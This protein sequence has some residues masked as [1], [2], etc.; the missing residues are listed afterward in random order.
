MLINENRIE[1]T[2]NELLL[3]TNEIKKKKIRKHTINIIAGQIN[4][5]WRCNT[6]VPIKDNYKKCNIN[7]RKENKRDL[8][9]KLYSVDL[10]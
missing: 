7:Y 9:R 2:G 1:L 10:T 3:I 6:V 8:Q 4:K 5:Y